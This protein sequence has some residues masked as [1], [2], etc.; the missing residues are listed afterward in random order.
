[1]APCSATSSASTGRF[2]RTESNSS[3]ASLSYASSVRAPLGTAKVAMQGTAVN[4]HS[5]NAGE[6]AGKLVTPAAAIAPASRH[7]AS[8][9][10]V[11]SSRMSWEPAGTCSTRGGIRGRRL[12]SWF[13]NSPLPDFIIGQ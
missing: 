1:M 9:K 3:A 13:R 11:R 4:P 12:D 5:S 2:C 10:R 6:H 8:G 7:R